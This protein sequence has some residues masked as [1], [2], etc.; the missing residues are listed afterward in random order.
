MP[1]EL[2]DLDMDEVDLAILALFDLGDDYGVTPSQMIRLI[3]DRLD[4]AA[5]IAD[6]AA[7][8][9]AFDEV[10]RLLN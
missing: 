4:V 10:P 7:D 3:R 5:E 9:A 1:P 8:S 2:D 6:M